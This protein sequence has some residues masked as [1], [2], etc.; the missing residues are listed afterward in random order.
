[1]ISE[2][3]LLAN[4][5]NALRSTGPRTAEGKAIASQNAVKHG[6]RAENTVIPGENPE[7]FDQF[8]QLLLEDLAP[9]GAMEVFL[10]D[11]IVAAFWKLQRAGRIETELLAELNCLPAKGADKSDK[12][13]LPF[14][15]M[16]TKTYECPVHH[17]RLDQQPPPD[18]CQSCPVDADPENPAFDFL[19]SPKTP[20]QQ[21]L[22]QVPAEF[23]EEKQL[24]G[25][26]QDQ[27]QAPSGQPEP[28][29]PPEL[30]RIFKQDM[31]SSNILAR[32][33]LYEGQIERS[34]YKALAEL[35]KL[36]LLRSKMW[37]NPPD[38]PAD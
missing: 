19:K 33:R 1:M 22:P 16:L 21:L 35:Q 26:H 30:G 3:Q 29:S 18:G 37:I 20:D 24:P 25:S 23:S 14:K 38:V 5:Q 28:S 7:E 32:F 31:A 8:R 13:D 10:A 12:S 27:T 6:L 17:K 36:Q 11:R 9:V 34:L 4:R 15:I 2:K